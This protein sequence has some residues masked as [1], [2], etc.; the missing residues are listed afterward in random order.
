[1]LLYSFSIELYFKR[2]KL[3]IFLITH[4]LWKMKKE[5][6]SLGTVFDEKNCFSM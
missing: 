5:G 2:K 4:N 3:N 1:M 6:F